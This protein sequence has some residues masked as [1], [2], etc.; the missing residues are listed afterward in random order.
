MTV[1]ALLGAAQTWAQ[2]LPPSADPGQIERRLQPRDGPRSKPGAFIPAPEQAP[3]PADAAS[4]KFVLLTVAIHGNT[5]FTQE[6]LLPLF[7]DLLNREV[8]LLEVY[9]ARD[10]VTAKYRDAGY[11]LTQAVIPQQIITGGVL[12]VEIVNGVINNVQIHG[13]A[14]DRLG[15]IEAY[16]AKI[17]AARPLRSAVLER[18]VLLMNDLPGV[19]V[20]TVLSASPGATAGSDLDLYVEESAFRY[21]AGADNRGTRE[22]GKF[23]VNGGFDANNLLG[24]RDR[25][26]LRGVVTAQ[27]RELRYIQL[28]ESL[29]VSSEGAVVSFNAVNSQ[30]KPGG[31]VR[32]LDLVS[33]GQSLELGIDHPVIRTRAKTLRVTASFKMRDDEVTALGTG[34]SQD[35]LSILSVGASFDVSDA[36]QGRNLIGLNV[37]HGLDIF[38]ATETGSASLSRAGG[39]SDFTSLNFSALR[40]QPFNERLGGT[41]ALAGQRSGVPLLSSQQFGVGGSQFGR[42]FDYSTLTGDSGLGLLAELAYRPPAELGAVKDLQVYGSLDGGWVKDQGGAARQSLMSA[43]AG[44]RVEL[45]AASI[46]LEADKPLRA[47]GVSDKDWQGFFSVSTKF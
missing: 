20:R 42:A 22:V 34:I 30:S 47:D 25:L 18:Y 41:F 17:Q 9:A 43:G 23:E 28:N 14:G 40:E 44:V 16:A 45:G 1:L 29:P 5:V 26:S 38:G 8:S 36:W 33:S 7:E 3:P 19:Q 10:A 13:S 2:Q 37:A 12:R 4:V 39:H 27:I 31:A 32:S 21:S 46:S 35:R 11:V 6:E 15:L 24:L